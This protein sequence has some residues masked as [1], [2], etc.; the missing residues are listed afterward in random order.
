M[1]LVNWVVGAVIGLQSVYH[2]FCKL[3]VA[4]LFL[5]D[6]KMGSELQKLPPD[7][8]GLEY[9]IERNSGRRWKD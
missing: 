1:A 5:R 2:V 6:Q 7:I 8:P 3:V 4:T 9:L